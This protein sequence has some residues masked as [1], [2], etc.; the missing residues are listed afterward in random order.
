MET[1]YREEEFLE[2][3]EKFEAELKEKGVVGITHKVSKGKPKSKMELK[4][5]IPEKPFH[6]GNVLYD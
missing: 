2:E 5:K 3:F 1:N 6:F 4:M